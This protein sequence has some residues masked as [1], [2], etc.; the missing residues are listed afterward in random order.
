M[1]EAL[2]EV[3][4]LLRDMN[5]TTK[6]PQFKGDIMYIVKADNPEVGFTLSFT[7][8]DSEGNETPDA[9]LSVTAE[10]DNEDAVQIALDGT[11][12]R[13]GTVKFGNPG[14]A[15]LNVTVK[16]ANDRLLG[17]FGAQF[18][19]T[20]GDPSSIAGGS[21]SFEGLTEA[22]E[23]PTPTPTEPVPAPT[24]EEPTPAEPTP[25]EPTP[26]EPT[27]VEPTEPAPFPEPVPEPTPA[28][29]D[30]TIDPVDP[31]NGDMEPRSGRRR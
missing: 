2:T 28:P 11:T 31:V 4:T 26:A 29:E 17:S 5:S 19:V 14:L 10:S 9:N 22:S 18:T 8:K 30:G 25:T 13:A 7:A 23:E 3:I 27:P 24:P 6:Q 21:L 1:R 16:D 15:N 20:V 12:G